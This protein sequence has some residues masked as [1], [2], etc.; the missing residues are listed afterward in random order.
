MKDP[1]SQLLFEFSNAIFYYSALI[2]K[3]L[4]LFFSQY[5]IVGH[6]EHVK[7]GFLTYKVCLLVFKKCLL[8]SGC[9]FSSC[10]FARAWSS[11]SRTG[12]MA[13]MCDVGKQFTVI[14]PSFQQVCL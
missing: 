1:I 4:I 14:C 11:I 3:A 8:N 10:S 7:S 5:C 12:F 6:E 9:H 13:W 2:N